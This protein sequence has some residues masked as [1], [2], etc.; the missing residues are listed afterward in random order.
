[1]PP[2]FCTSSVVLLDD[3]VDDVVDGDD[4]EHVAAPSTT[5]TASRSYLEISRATSSRS[6]SGGTVIGVAV[7]RHAT[8]IG[9]SGLAGD[10][11]AQR[12]R[13]A[14]AAC[15]LGSST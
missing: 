6:V 10:Q 15:V 5:G 14:P 11:P 4:A 7:R 13:A 3:R 12:D 8:A 9:R 1:M 2:N